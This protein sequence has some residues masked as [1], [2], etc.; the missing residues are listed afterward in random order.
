MSLAGLLGQHVSTNLRGVELISDTSTHR[1][2]GVEVPVQRYDISDF[3]WWWTQQMELKRYFETLT[4]H[5]SPYRV[6]IVFLNHDTFETVEGLN[7]ALGLSFE[8][9]EECLGRDLSQ[10]KM[11]SDIIYLKYEFLSIQPNQTDRVPK[12]EKKCRGYF[13]EIETYEEKHDKGR[14]YHALEATF[15]AIPKTNI[16]YERIE[17][18]REDINIATDTTH[19]PGVM[20]DEAAWRQRRGN[21]VARR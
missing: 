3:N 2:L 21:L 15:N 1:Y 5:D 16:A 10:L 12:L 4:I 13:G 14:V 11:I 9:Q 20:E 19:H 6:P 8:Y 18:I 17:A 7:P